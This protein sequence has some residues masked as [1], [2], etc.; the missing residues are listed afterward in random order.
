MKVLVLGGTRYFGKRLV[1]LL[2][3]NG[4]QVTVASTGKTAVQFNG[5]V[6]RVTVDRKSIDSLATISQGRHWD[7]VYD[8]LCFNEYEAAIA[9]EIFAKKVSHFVLTSSQSVYDKG[10]GVEESDF[11]AK[12]YI[13]NKNCENSYQEGKRLAEKI[14]AGQSNF[15]TTIIR[16]PI[17]LGL[18][19]YTRR[20][21]WHVARVKFEKDIYFPNPSAKLAFISSEEA[22]K[23]MAW[24][25]DRKIFGPINA[26]SSAFM[27]LLELIQIIEEKVGTKAI[28]TANASDENK[29]PYGVKDDLAMSNSRAIELKFP[30]MTLDNWLP[31]LISEITKQSVIGDVSR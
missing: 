26:C 8:Q 23:F 4:H 3:W 25:L 9:V 28:L 22:A 10:I 30:F 2:A 17:V 16:F 20:L 27:S 1:D 13:P 18:D 5:A 31:N 19:D 12:T 24:L 7:V 15:S 11:D 29:S 14:L 21:H 6:E